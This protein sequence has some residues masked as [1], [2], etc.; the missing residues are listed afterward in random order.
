MEDRQLYVSKKIYDY[1]VEMLYWDRYICGLEDYILYCKPDKADK[2]RL[3]H[4]ITRVKFHIFR[5]EIKIKKYLKKHKFSKEFE[6]KIK[7]FYNDT[8]IKK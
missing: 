3:Q 1:Q 4:E 8:K 2:F 6:Q 7:T 5:Q